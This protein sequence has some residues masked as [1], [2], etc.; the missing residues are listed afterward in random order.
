MARLCQNADMTQPPPLASLVGYRLKQAQA[1]LRA[2]MDEALRPLG[3]TTAQYATLELLSRNP[4]A[5]TSQLARDAFVT[6]QTMSTLLIGLEKRGVVERTRGDAGGRALPT[7]LTDKGEAMRAQAAEIA[8]GIERRM[9]ERL[10]ESQAAALHEALE[11]C[12]EALEP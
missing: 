8:L 3:L 5:S 7:L 2:R 11:Q 4:G 9:V 12:I 10:D 6:R 1:V